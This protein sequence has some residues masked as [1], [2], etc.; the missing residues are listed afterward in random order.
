[1]KD[2]LNHATASRLAQQI[3]AV[4]PTFDTDR[5]LTQATA[6]LD[7][8][9]LSARVTAFAEALRSE[10]PTSVPEA[11]AILR[12]SL[13]PVCAVKEFDWTAWHLWPIGQFIATHGLDHYDQSLAALTELT[14]RFTAEFAIR[15]FAIRYPDR[16]PRDLLRLTTHES[17]TVRR[18]CSEGLRPRL[19]WAAQLPALIADPTPVLPILEALHADPSPDVRRSV[20]NHLNDIAKD[21]PG[22]VVATCRR[23][24]ASGNLTNARRLVRH[25]LRTL[26]KSGHADALALLGFAPVSGV[27]ARLTISPAHAAIG[28]GVLLEATLTSTAARP[29]DIALDYAVHYQRK[30]G[31]TSRKV[32]KGKILHLPANGTAT[33]R[34]RHSLARTTTRALYPGD[35]AVDLVAN[36]TTLAR[37]SFHLA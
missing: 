15:P 32:F 2:R 35:H 13:P 23:W 26:V 9:E 17:A 14:Q 18:W 33:V 11:I 8:L 1:M 24:L 25:A 3:L 16:V 4:H 30:R 36:G 5:Y 20:A 7:R 22:L 19:P 37:S 31:T 10:L 12:A 21:H 34:K 27:T 28:A 29:Q 6:N